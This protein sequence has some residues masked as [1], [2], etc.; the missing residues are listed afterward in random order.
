[1]KEIWPDWRNGQDESNW[2]YQWNNHGIY[3]GL[4][5]EAYIDKCIELWDLVRV[6]LIFANAGVHRTPNPEQFSILKRNL[7]IT[8]GGYQPSIIC[9]G[10]RANKRVVLAE[11]RFC[12]N[13]TNHFVS[14]GRDVN[15]YSKNGKIT[16]E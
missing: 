4:S 16:F 6:D 1:L 2:E 10:D 12:L 14:C 13:S 3:S 5:Q 9:K 11:I 7:K 8:M 15:C